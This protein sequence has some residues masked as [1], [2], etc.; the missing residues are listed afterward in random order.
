M[1][2]TLMKLE[3]TVC[4]TFSYVKYNKDLK[5]QIIFKYFTIRKGLANKTNHNI[6]F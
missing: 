4:A 6:V 5:V 2:N 3:K 1:V